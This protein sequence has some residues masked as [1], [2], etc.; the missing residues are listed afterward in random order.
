V[1]GW[2]AEALALGFGIATALAVG[3]LTAASFALRT[4]LART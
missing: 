1:R 3:G 4:R 2:D